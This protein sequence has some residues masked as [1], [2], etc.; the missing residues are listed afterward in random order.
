VLLVDE[1]LA[2]GDAARAQR[3]RRVADMWHQGNYWCM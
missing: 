1:I 3:G 2:E